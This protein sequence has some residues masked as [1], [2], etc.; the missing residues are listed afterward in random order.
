VYHVSVF[1]PRY[2]IFLCHEQPKF[3]TVWIILLLSLVSQLGSLFVLHKGLSYLR[4]FFWV[5]VSM[6]PLIP[7]VLTSDSFSYENT[8]LASVPLFFTLLTFYGLS[9]IHSVEESINELSQLV[10]SSYKIKSA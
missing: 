6:L 7:A 10:E 9:E 2:G 3:D 4:V 1:L 5:I 8:G